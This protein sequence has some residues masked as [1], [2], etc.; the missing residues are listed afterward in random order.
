MAEST[1]SLTFEDLGRS[2]A[3]DLGWR[4][5]ATVAEGLTA[6]QFANV[7]A[8]N[9]AG[10]R[11][12]LVAHDW[13]FKRPRTTFTLWATATGTVSATS[14]VVTA[15]V[16]KFFPS[17]IGHNILIEAILN[18]TFAADTDWDKGA[19]WTIASGVATATGAISTDLGQTVNPLVVGNTYRVTF[20]TTRTAGSITPVC[21]TASGTARSAGGTFTE[22]IVATST[23]V[24]KFTTSGF[25]GTLDDVTVEGVFAITG[26]TSDTVIVVDSDATATAKA[27]T[28]TADGNYRL[29]DDFGSLY[30]TKLVFAAGTN[31]SRTIKVTSESLVAAAV[32]RNANT[33]RP[34]MAGVR[35]LVIGSASGQRFDL[36]VHPIPDQDYVVNFRFEVHPDALTAGLY[37]Y[38]GLKFAE[39][40]RQA[41]LA[42]AE[43]MF[44]DHKSNRR[45][46]Y[47]LTL[48]TAIADDRRNN[49][50]ERLGITRDRILGRLDHNDL[51]DLS[52]VTVQGVSFD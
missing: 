18:G 50:S 12:F 20:T 22:D 9:Q 27:F 42:S 14:T 21:G 25:T 30:S 46:E 19:G 52:A 31:D 43:A 11:D 48:R 39:T 33:A 41:C 32:Q 13:S 34:T 6:A 15:T 51:I 3:F 16:A 35:P 2:T 24:F 38:G 47:A 5:F 8:A 17:M 28:V 10:Y 4:R 45:S 40:I 37:P 29:M 23:T 49:R 44:N 26:Y 1:L 7:E 36:A